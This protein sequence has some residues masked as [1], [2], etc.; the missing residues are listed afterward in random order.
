MFAIRPRFVR[1]L[2]AFTCAAT[3]VSYTASAPAQVASGWP[4]LLQSPAHDSYSADPSISSGNA[5]GVGVKWMANLFS[6]DLGSPVVAYN[7]TLNKEVVYVGDERADVFAVDAGTGQLIWSTNVGF[8]DAIRATPAVAPDGSVW[9]GTNY[10]A[11]LY[12][13]N[14]ATGA[15]ECS[16]KGLNGQAIMGS[17]MIVTPAG[18]ILSVYWDEI[19]SAGVP[20]S[21]PLVATNESSCAQEFVY[22]EDAGSWATPA[23]AVDATGEPLVIAGT[24]DPVSTMYAVDANTG[25]LVWKF[26][27]YNPKDYDVGDAST[28]SAPGNNGFADGVLYVN[29][30]FGIEYALDL[31]KGTELWQY[32]IYPT[33]W[34]GLQNTISSA[35]LDGNRIVFGYAN[36]LTSL[37]ATTGS[38]LWNWSGPA[39]V[40]SSPAIIGPSGSEVVAFADYTGA[41]RLFS[42]AAGSQLYAYQT[43]GYITSSPAEYNGTI[44]I[45]SSDGFLYA[46]SE[47]G[48]NGSRPNTTLTAPANESV[49]ANPNGSLTV[50]GKSS[51]ASSVAA[52]EVAIQSGGA[53]GDWY[54]ATAGSWNSGPVRNEA[55]LASPGASS[56]NWSFSFPVPVAGGSY[57]VYAN[58]VNGSHIVDKGTQI[59]FTV[60]PSKNQATLHTSV[61][62]APP[63]STFKVTGNAF[64]PGETVTFS[65]LGTTVG[66]A[67]AGKTGNVPQTAIQVPV[68]A[69]FGPVSLTATGDTSGKTGSTTVYVTNEWTQFGYGATRTGNEPN[70]DVIAH[71]IDVGK[72]TI[73]G[74]SW[75]YNSGAA[76][77]T[78]PAVV[79]GVAYF[80]ND[81]GVLTA[82][83]T[84]A[85]SPIWS[86]TIPSGSPIRSSPAVDESGQIVFGAND[87]NLYVLNSSG[88]LMH[89]MALGGDLGPAAYANGDIVIAS[90]TGTIYSIADSTWTTNWS[91]NAGGTIAAAPA[92][93][94]HDGIVIVGTGGGNVI[95]YSAGTGRVRWTTTT[96]GAIN[97]IAI[98]NRSVYV[99]SADGNF[100]A[101][102]ENSGSREFKSAADSGVNAVDV[103]GGGNISFGTAKG[104]VYQTKPGGTRLFTQVGHYGNTPIVGLS[105]ADANA[106][107]TSQG[108]LIGVTREVGTEALNPWTYQTRG[109]LG[110]P[111]AIL[112]GTVYVGAD[113]GNL[114]AFTPNGA[115]PQS[116]VRA[117]GAII[118]VKGAW[119]CTSPP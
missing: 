104:T 70:D 116:T 25:N 81:A 27:T 72:N 117:G 76:I 62:D 77:N 101:F 106:V 93:D 19:A 6:T 58:T 66:T 84:Q 34:T 50:T 54:D 48:G 17:P 40:A 15:V 56:T 35:A 99:G 108:G 118:T 113:D 71:T 37:N 73:L 109:A 92:F 105:S 57:K 87:G 29:N 2:A 43:G 30:K 28:I 24:A 97:S 32:S 42:L 26:K 7:A 53:S 21:G 55:M 59:S 79:N 65:L 83:S 114:Y 16:M 103:G 36:G 46:F 63:G 67:T 95:A 1:T 9:V 11:K 91:A 49:V 68:A 41:F 74:V 82:V 112:N 44:Y 18:G 69:P 96:G 102:T 13:L 119:A 8:R 98:S 39:E 89:T 3:V 86:Y 115:T 52:V 64:K 94:A 75:M 5:S 22:E 111:P 60:S 107:G 78:E 47:G 110:A 85:G 12:K 14:G 45:A 80:G 33:D 20:A 61:E 51:D 90:S 31:T 23:Y 88:T 4:Q 38:V 10:N 100:Y